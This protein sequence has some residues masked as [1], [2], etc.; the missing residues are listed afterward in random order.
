MPG[1][2]PHLETWLLVGGLLLG[3]VWAIGY[4][5]PR[6]AP[7]GSV[8]A[9]PARKTAFLFGL[10][11]LLAG[12]E[13]P[14][15]DLAEGYLFSGH[16]VQHMLFAYVVPPLLILGT[17]R[18]LYR[19]IIGTGMRRAVYRFVTR[20]MIAFVLLNGA[21]AAMHWV[22]VVNLQ[23]SS[24]VFHLAFHLLLLGAGVAMWSIVL[25]PLP[26]YARLTEPFKMMY[27][28][29]QSIIP[30]VPAS[31]LTFSEG[32]FYDAYARAPRVWE[33]LDPVTDQRIAGLIM[34]VGGGLLLWTAIAIVFFRWN[35]KEEQS[36]E[37]ETVSWD[38]FEREL[39]AWDLRKP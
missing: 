14:I 30:T 27:L 7:A 38:D 37:I 6:L 29:L 15:H 26:E 23:L 12:E 16:M 9:S 31:F 19:R 28:F 3:Y 34:K 10:F 22:P 1:P 24:E 36:K 25:D 39:E 8:V 18:W 11:F 35:A 17:P 2:H 5:G 32:T 33:W 20:P 13:W 4:V 21:I